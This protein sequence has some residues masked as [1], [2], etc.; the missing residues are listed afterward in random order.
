MFGGDF[1]KTSENLWIDWRITFKKKFGETLDFKE[2]PKNFFNKFF[3]K[4]E[5]TF[6]EL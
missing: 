2:H 5:E 1:R 3:I 6:R 4:F